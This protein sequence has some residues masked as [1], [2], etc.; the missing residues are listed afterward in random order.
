VLL[1]VVTNAKVF[2]SSLVYFSM[3]EK[4]TYNVDEIRC[5]S[6][7]YATMLHIEGIIP[8]ID[9]LVTAG[10]IDDE[11]LGRIRSID[12]YLMSYRQLPANVRNALELE[13]CAQNLEGKM[14]EWKTRGKLDRF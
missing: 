12:I 14:R 4:A 6:S 13:G 3:E 9:K 7:L 1:S 10:D 8:T 11:T 2:K 5:I